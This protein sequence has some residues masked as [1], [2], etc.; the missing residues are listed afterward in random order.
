MRHLPVA[1]TLLVLTVSALNAE[2]SAQHLLE[3]KLHASLQALDAQLPG[4]MGVATIDLTSGRI[5]VYNGE[6]VF[7]T[8]STIKIPIMAQMFREKID[9]EKQVT[10]QPADA[11]GGAGH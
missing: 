11:V 8:A 3:E 7:P 10:V 4:V 1:C 5:F 6:A 2:S 9:L